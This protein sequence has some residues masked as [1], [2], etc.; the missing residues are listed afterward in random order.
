[1]YR[2]QDL[3]PMFEPFM[4]RYALAVVWTYVCDIDTG[5]DTGVPCLNREARC[6]KSGIEW[7]RDS[8]IRFS[9]KMIWT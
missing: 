5:Y 9:Q 7:V 3:V 8:R 2:W 4:A 6:Y 1:L